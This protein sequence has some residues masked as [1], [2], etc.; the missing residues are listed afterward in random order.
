MDLELNRLLSKLLNRSLKR[1][2]ELLKGSLNASEVANLLRVPPQTPL[3]WAKEHLLLAVQDNGEWRFPLC[4]F[5][6]NNPSGLVPGLTEILKAMAANDVAEL[7]MLS[8]LMQPDA[9][10]EGRS[11]IELLRTHEPEQFNRVLY[12]A[13]ATG[14]Y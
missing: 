8:W 1:Q 12:A 14:V 3:D 9:T 13:R 7:A 4:Q 5:D 10:F 2:A 6:S 11:P